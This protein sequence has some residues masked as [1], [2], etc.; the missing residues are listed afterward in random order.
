MTNGIPSTLAVP[1]FL[2]GAPR[3]GSAARALP[4]PLLAVRLAEIGRQCL[5]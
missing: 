3:D 2:W 5:Y 1:V 4:M